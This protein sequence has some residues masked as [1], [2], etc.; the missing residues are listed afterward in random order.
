MYLTLLITCLC[1]FFFKLFSLDDDVLLQIAIGCKRN[2]Q[3]VFGTEN[4]FLKMIQHCRV[5]SN[6]YLKG[7]ILILH[8]RY[9]KDIHRQECWCN[10]CNCQGKNR[11][12]GRNYFTFPPTLVLADINPTESQNN[13]KRS[14]QKSYCNK[15]VTCTVLPTLDLFIRKPKVW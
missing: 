14:R 15:Y 6:T 2:T 11:G 5:G 10:K 1:I 7:P 9:K 12:Y 8:V 3:I 4:H 13:L